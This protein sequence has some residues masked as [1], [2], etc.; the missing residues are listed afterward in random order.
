MDDTKVQAQ[1]LSATGAMS[2]RT[3]AASAMAGFFIGATRV[4]GQ[5][6]K[7]NEQKLRVF[8]VG[9]GH[10]GAGDID[11]LAMTGDVI[12]TGL[13]DVSPMAFPK[14]ARDG[15]K[16]YPLDGVP[17]PTAEQVKAAEDILCRD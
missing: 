16:F 2:R 5:D 4:Y 11:R 15:N 7:R 12:F 8:K 9:T 3:F 14:A 6:V 13:C 10:M 1:Q 17:T